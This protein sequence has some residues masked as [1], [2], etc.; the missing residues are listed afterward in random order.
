LIVEVMCAALAGAF[1]GPQMGSFMA[2]DGKPIGCGQFFIALAPDGFSGDQF[3]R[4]VTAL[5]KSITSQ[6]G[7]RLPNSRRESNQKRLTKEGL[8]L[9][10]VLYE[11]LKS[12]A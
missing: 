8:P 5:A 10:K 4:Q 3:A 9:D 2:N 6:K 12:F 11:R 7:A 1:R